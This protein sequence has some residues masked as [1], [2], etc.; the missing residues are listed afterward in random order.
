MGL[1]LLSLPII[2]S[3]VRQMQRTQGQSI[4]SRIKINQRSSPF[5][6]PVN[7]ASTRYCSG[8]PT[9]KRHYSSGGC[10]IPC[11]PL[12]KSGSEPQAQAP[13]KP[14]D[15]SL[16]GSQKGGPP[17]KS[18]FLTSCVLDSMRCTRPVSEVMRK[19]AW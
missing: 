9:E 10:W 6:T 7:S 12:T 16:T 1:V 14:S 2:S 17:E 11:T 3:L 5:F 8:T 13:V 15:T 18:H 19:G 4:L